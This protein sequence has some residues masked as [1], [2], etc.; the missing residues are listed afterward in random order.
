MDKKI[1]VND[2][3]LDHSYFEPFIAPGVTSPSYEPYDAPSG[4]LCANFNTVSFFYNKKHQI[5]SAEAQTPL[6]PLVLSKI[7]KSGLKQGR[8]LLN[9]DEGS[10]YA[11]F[12]I[13]DFLNK[14]GINVK[15]NIRLGKLENQ[16]DQLIYSYESPFSLK[17]IIIKLL[18]FS[19]NFIANQLFVTIGAKAFGAPG[20]LEKGINAVNKY[21]ENQLGLTNI[22]IV[23]GSGISR[24]NKLSARDMALLLKEFQN[25]RTLMRTK[26]NEFYKTGTL[27]GVST[28]I[29]YFTIPDKGLFP[30]V[31]FLNTP[32]KKSEKIEGLIYNILCN[33]ET[34]KSD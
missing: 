28:R 18:R 21:A 27:E 8:I 22:S 14:R 29:G 19:N 33:S 6:V 26:N 1:S 13:K 4:A 25:H 24:E 31:I 30:F 23:E 7:K 15:G 34:D 17:D 9:S 2:I 20:S 5:V 32:H 3:I 11:G 10:V 16:G 12:L